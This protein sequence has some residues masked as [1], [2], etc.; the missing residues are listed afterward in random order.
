MVLA[1]QIF[2]FYVIYK[3]SVA[4]STYFS[5]GSRILQLIVVLYILYGHDR[6][7]YKS[8]WL[9]LIM[10]LPIGGIIIY[11]LWGASKSRFLH[12]H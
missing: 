12:P 5:S 10:F 2:I 6:L 1:V 3:G 9:I 11:F 8:P 4:F 7:A